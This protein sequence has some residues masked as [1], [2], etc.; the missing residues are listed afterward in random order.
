MIYTMSQAWDRAL[1]RAR[2][3]HIQ[4]EQRGSDG[5]RA[6]FRAGSFSR[7]GLQHGVSVEFGAAGVSVRCSCEGGQHGRPCQHAAAA[8]NAAALLPESILEPE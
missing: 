4:V 7:D 8:L 5:D 6:W 1:H 3:R 2:A